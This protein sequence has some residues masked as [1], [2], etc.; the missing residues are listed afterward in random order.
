MPP[1]AYELVQKQNHPGIPRCLNNCNITRQ[2]WGIWWLQSALSSS[3]NQIQIDFSAHV[4]LKFDRWP[5]QTIGNLLHAPRS[6]V[7]H[8][9]AIHIFKLEL[10]PRNPQIPSQ[11]INFSAFVTLKFDGWPRKTK[12]TPLM[13]LKVLYIISYLFVNSNWSYSPETL[14]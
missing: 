12:D 13:L 8:F 9:I 7:C 4:T 6:Y 11:I 10:S 5:W 14:N 1:A 3:S 2:I